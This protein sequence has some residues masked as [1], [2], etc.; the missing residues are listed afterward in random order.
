M[1]V[2]ADG[3]L[4]LFGGAA[5][6]PGGLYSDTW[7]WSESDGWSRRAGP[8]EPAAIVRP[9]AVLPP[10]GISAADALRLAA[11]QAYFGQNGVAVRAVAG[12]AR[13]FHHPGAGSPGGDRH[14][15]A[16]LFAGTFPPAS[17]G[18]PAR[19]PR[20]HAPHTSA[21]VLLDYVTGEFVRATIPAPP[22]LTGP[23]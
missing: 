6:L 13:D 2:D 1:A 8:A 10:T 3:K 19:R 9:P 5:A 14:V 4:V 16:V 23:P 15:W 18:P 17:A 22:R 21:C 20:H 11:T 7:T 12:C